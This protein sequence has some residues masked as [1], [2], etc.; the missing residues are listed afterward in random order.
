[1]HSWCSCS[2]WRAG[3]RFVVIDY[4]VIICLRQEGEPWSWEAIVNVVVV[5]VVDGVNYYI[6]DCYCCCS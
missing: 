3:R 6:N 4:D 2:Y 1:M 5:V